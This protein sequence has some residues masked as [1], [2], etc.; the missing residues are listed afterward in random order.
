MG[1][2]LKYNAIDNLENKLTKGRSMVL[3]MQNFR[4]KHINGL[5]ASV[6]CYLNTTNTTLKRQCLKH[7]L[8]LG[9]YFTEMDNETRP[10]GARMIG[11]IHGT[12]DLK[13]NNLIR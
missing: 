8:Y 13:G 7:N 2:C 9:S 10:S 5:A 6:L 12:F 3:F 1:Q 4:K 11:D